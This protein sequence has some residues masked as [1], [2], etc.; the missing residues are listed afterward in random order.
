M[1]KIWLIA[2]YI[3]CSLVQD[4]KYLKSTNAQILR[5]YTE[6]LLQSL[7]NENKKWD[8][9]KGLTCFIYPSKSKLISLL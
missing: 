9:S 7:T 2:S 3:V 6:N 8:I 4:G 1:L 5:K